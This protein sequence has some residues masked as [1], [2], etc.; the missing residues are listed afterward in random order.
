MGEKRGRVGRKEEQETENG[1]LAGLAGVGTEAE[2][3]FKVTTSSSV[4]LKNRS[5]NN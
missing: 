5:G 1:A 2:R 4:R 3:G